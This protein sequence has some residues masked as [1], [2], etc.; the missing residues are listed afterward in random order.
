MW[1]KHG[2]T[3]FRSLNDNGIHTASIIRQQCVQ[4]STWEFTWRTRNEQK[5]NASRSHCFYC[6]SFT[7]SLLFVYCCWYFCFVSMSK[8]ISFSFSFYFSFSLLNIARW[9]RWLWQT[10][11]THTHTRTNISGE[12]TT[13]W[14]GG[15]ILIIGSLYSYRC[16]WMDH[17]FRA[18]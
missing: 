1:G 8:L 4:L 15:N 17:V 6:V 3:H 9:L 7:S 5:S 11:R 12:T 18:N 2:G 14:N 16:P 10:A 13:C